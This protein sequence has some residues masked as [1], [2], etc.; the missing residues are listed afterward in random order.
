[1][2]LLS[3]CSLTGSAVIGSDDQVTV[4][5]YV[6]VGFAD[7]G[8]GESDR[9]PRL[10]CQLVAQVAP[11]L[12]LEA[13]T[14]PDDLNAAGCHATG[15]IPLSTLSA[16]LP[17]GRVGDR[18]LLAIPARA[19]AG[20]GAAIGVPVGTP[21]ALSITFPVTIETHDARSSVSGTTVW[22][23][24]PD[25]ADA[26]RLFATAAVPT[27]HPEIPLA[28]L[29]GLAIGGLGAAARFGRRGPRPGPAGAAGGGP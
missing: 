29:A 18:Y 10:A 7:V 19:I 15:T 8:S 23:L 14:A 25:A 20:S 3:G 9:D 11:G 5:G 13:L 21:T 16:S 12:S 28:I 17:V 27:P 26:P 2:P 4:D 1:M 22:W 24:E 6:W